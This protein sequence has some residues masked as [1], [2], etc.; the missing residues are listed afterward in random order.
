[1]ASDA[2]ILDG[3]GGF[4]NGLNSSMDPDALDAGTV[5]RAFNLV[6][7]GSI[8]QA[9]PGFEQKNVY[10]D[11]AFQGGCVFRPRN[12]P[13]HVLFAVA[14]KVYVSHAPFETYTQLRGLQFDA[15]TPYLYFEPAAQQAVQ[16]NDDGSLKVI[17]PRH[18]CVI[19]DGLSK[20]GYYDG[21]KAEH[22]DEIPIGTVMAW[23]GDRLW[24]AR[25]SQVFA[26]DYAN[27]FGYEEGKY[28]GST[29]AFVFPGRVTALARSD[30]VGAPFMLVFTLDKTFSVQTSVRSRTAW[31]TT[32]NFIY[33][34]FPSIG[35][36]GH[37]AWV[38][39]SGKLWWFSS[40][41]LVSMDSAEQS[42]VKSAFVYIDTPMAFSKRY[43]SSD[44]T[45]VALG[46]VENYLLVSVPYTDRYN[47]HTWVLDSSITGSPDDMEQGKGWQGVW[48]GIRPIAWVTGTIN[49][50]FR[51]LAL[52]VDRDGKNRMWETFKPDRR[53]NGCPFW[54]GFET[55]G[56]GQKDKSI[57]RFRYVDFVMSE[58]EGDQLFAKVM[59]AGTAIGPYTPIAVREF[60]VLRGSI[61]YDATIDAMASGIFAL[62]K[63][64][65]DWRTEDAISV[66]EHPLSAC[67]VETERIEVLD[68]AFQLCVSFLGPGAVRYIRVWGEPQTEKRSGTCPPEETDFR[69]SRFDGSGFS[70]S[71]KAEVLE[72]LSA[73]LDLYSASATATAVYRGVSVVGNGSATSGISQDAANALAISIAQMRAAKKLELTAPGYLGGGNT[74][75]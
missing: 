72:A 32:Q 37:L 59:Y 8:L 9:R 3:D 18:V 2:R 48:T 51:A 19:Q 28:I 29:G 61:S 45:G 15:N 52:S 67:G 44:L 34:I 6:M 71:S 26:S 64:S 21:S 63:Q 24:I 35:C 47:R 53:D 38:L 54:W 27:P 36:V 4:P 30:S 5:A 11:G 74:C 1:M 42:Y 68:R 62:R 65:R 69:G 46:S 49:D 22:T 57:S 20:A 12:A 16:I 50:E 39:H 41:G 55:R 43:L 70:A 10:P 56:Y 17:D 31:E 23:S 66:E 14:G 73:G 40:Q 60:K 58:I 13:A 25:E 75:A 7:R 33:D